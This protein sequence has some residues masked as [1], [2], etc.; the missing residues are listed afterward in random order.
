MPDTTVLEVH[1]PSSSQ[2]RTLEL[3][4][5]SVRI[6]RGPQCEV[7]LGE[8][9]LAEVQCLLRRRGDTWHVQPVGPPGYLSIRGRP[10]ESQRP[11]PLGEPM[12]VGDHWLRLSRLRD[13]DLERA[14]TVA[15]PPAPVPAPPAPARSVEPAESPRA[16]K[17]AR[18]PASRLIPPRPED[19]RWEG[20][21]LG[22]GIRERIA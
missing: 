3:G 15:P 7:R 18:V 21:P 14:R 12:K 20:R 9:S 2:A 8:P 22:E 1:E 10:V 16:S 11:L 4:A 5:P 19:R 13:E 6:G 17:P